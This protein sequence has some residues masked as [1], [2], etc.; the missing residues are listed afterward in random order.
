MKLR[1]IISYSLGTFLALSS[2]SEGRGQDKM[3]PKPIPNAT[4]SDSSIEKSELSKSLEGKLTFSTGI[5]Y[6]DVSGSAGE[7][8][9]GLG[10]D[11]GISYLFS[12]SFIAGGKGYATF[13]YA[14]MDV[15][16]VD[17]EQSYEGII[18]AHHFGVSWGKAM[19]EMEMLA[20]AELGLTFTSL[21]TID[22]TEKKAS[23]E[24]GMVNVTLG[25]GADWQI[26]DKVKGG[27]R[28]YLGSGASTVFSLGGNVSFQF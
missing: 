3:T 1:K 2:V 17:G 28:V 8:T 14:P 6:N 16:V 5:G 24:D 13:R 10:G 15:I 11:F 25:G 18:E 19:G 12:E 26:F 23:L 27:P 20:S 21:H 22:N 9:S 7:W 4:P